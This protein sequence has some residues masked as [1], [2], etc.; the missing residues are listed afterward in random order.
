MLWKPLLP[1][2]TIHTR[3]APFHWEIDSVV[4][5]AEGKSE[6][7]LV[8]TERTTRA[9]IVLKVKDASR[10]NPNENSKSLFAT[11]IRS[12]VRSE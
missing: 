6:S 7:C 3:K 5:K 4:G 1:P 10:K 12:M 2:Y 9:E 11:A 8:M